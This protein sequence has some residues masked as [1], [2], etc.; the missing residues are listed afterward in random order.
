MKH[1]K[2]E[3]LSAETRALV[4]RRNF[5]SQSGAGLCSLALASMLAEDGFGFGDQYP[6]YPLAP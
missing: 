3:N 1:S 2:P 4:N 5:L 6:L